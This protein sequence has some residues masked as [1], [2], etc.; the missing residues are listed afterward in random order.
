MKF[1]RLKLPSWSLRSWV[2][3]GLLAVVVAMGLSWWGWWNSW[4][5][6]S[7]QSSNFTFDHGP[8]VLEDVKDIGQL[9]GATY[10][11]EVIHSWLEHQEA[12]DWIL[13]T[14]LYDEVQKMY[15]RQYKAMA[16]MPFRRDPQ[17]IVMS[18]SGR[19]RANIRTLSESGWYQAV[20]SPLASPEHVLLEEIR[21]T[22]WVKFAAK[23]DTELR[24]LRT[25]YRQETLED[26]ILIYLGRGK[27]LVGYDLAALQPEQMIRQGDTL[28]LDM[29]PIVISAS[30]S[31]WHLPV[32]QD[33]AGK[34]VPG[35]ESL[36][37]SGKVTPDIIRK[38]KIGCQQDLTRE[39][40]ARGVEAL[41]E[42]SAEQ[43]LLSFFNLLV[44]EEEQ[45]S[46]VDIR[47][48]DRYGQVQAWAADARIDSEELQQIRAAVE[49]DSL[50]QPPWMDQLRQR[51]GA[52]GHDPNWR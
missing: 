34:G 9:V 4:S 24:R 21:K 31:A 43:T 19:F 26:P 32:E 7:W 39:A 50:R 27:V 33:S 51:L 1:A 29:D 17:E 28:I 38:V 23:Y 13:L 8:T 5:L 15:S 52:W 16:D 30:I 2:A 45:L 18:A 10:Y 25:T 6:P 22:S 44:R 42:A 20:I 46:M 36:R 35:F 47:S 40:F 14:E 49:S 48:S 12:D 41:A 3:L 11:G 37:Q